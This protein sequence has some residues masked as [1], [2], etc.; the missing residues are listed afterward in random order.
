MTIIE[1][2]NQVKSIT[3]QLAIVGYPVSDKEKV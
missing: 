1:F 2:L 3:D